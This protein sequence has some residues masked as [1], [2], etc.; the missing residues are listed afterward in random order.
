MA[1]PPTADQ[2]VLIVD[3]DLGFVCWLGDI[4]KE[5]GCRALPALDCD[6]AVVV[7]ERLGVEPD[8]I[9]LNSS[10]PGAS[11]MLESYLQKNPHLKI[12]TI[13]PPANALGSSVHLHAIF[14]RPSP[15][16]LIVRSDWL[17][18]LRKLLGHVEAAGAR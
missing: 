15:S 2:T 9:I 7:A 3:D 11:Q 5:A 1:E 16:D 13:G 17:E 12:V 18:Q 8:V 4:F 10:L 14:E 6:A